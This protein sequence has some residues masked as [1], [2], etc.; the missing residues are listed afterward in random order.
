MAARTFNSLSA[1]DIPT[2][3]VT[4]SSADNVLCL[5]V[6]D[7]DLRRVKAL[8]EKTFELE[9]LHDYMAS[10]EVLSHV[11]IVVAIGEN[12]KGTP[13]IAGRVFGALGRHGINVVAIAQGSSELSISFAVKSSDV[14]EAVKAV[15]EEFKL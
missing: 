9:L 7:A 15:H 14:K 13:G 6:H 4:Q 11:A 1:E 10:I 5:A 3:M 8:L 12:M 2:L